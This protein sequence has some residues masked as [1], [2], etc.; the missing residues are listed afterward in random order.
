[1]HRKR[2]QNQL[3]CASGKSHAPRSGAWRGTAM[4]ASS[5]TL[6]CAVGDRR[7]GPGHPSVRQ[8]AQ[9]SRL[10][11]LSTVPLQPSMHNPRQLHRCNARLLVFLTQQKKRGTSSPL[12]CGWT[13]PIF[14]PVPAPIVKVSGETITA[15]HVR[16]P[17]FRQEQMLHLLGLPPAGSGQCH[18]RCRVPKERIQA[19]GPFLHHQANHIPGLRPGCNENNSPGLFDVLWVLFSAGRLV[20]LTGAATTAR[21]TTGYVAPGDIYFVPDGGKHG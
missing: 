5:L 18:R 9:I 17:P 14:T 2:F 13:L 16:V 21:G 4:S 12:A 10:V 7:R 15:P 8:S 11:Y 6:R 3:K 1:M 20:G 19:P